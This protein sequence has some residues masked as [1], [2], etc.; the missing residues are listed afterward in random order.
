MTKRSRLVVLL[1]L[2]LLS[3]AFL[4]LSYRLVGRFTCTGFSTSGIPSSWS[5]ESVL[6]KNIGKNTLFIGKRRILS[7]LSSLPYIESVTMKIEDGVLKV[8]GKSKDEA[9]LLYDGERLALLTEDNAFHLD[10]KDY[11]GLEEK[12]MTVKVSSSVMDAAIEEKSS[13]LS[14]FVGVLSSS[15]SSFGLITNAEYDNNKSSIF[16]G[17]LTINIPSL[18]STLTVEDMRMSEN[19]GEALSIIENEYLTS[20]ERLS[21]EKREYILGSSRLMVKR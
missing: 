8:D 2:S 15:F 13:V 19:L 18:E 7:Y 11:L 4:I 12:Y 16:S 6:S 1:I 3:L 17:F 10:G 5:V 9:L 21:E 14:P 20:R